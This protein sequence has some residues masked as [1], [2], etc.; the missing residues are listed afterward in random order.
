MVGSAGWMSAVDAFLRASVRRLPGNQR[1][2]ATPL[3][4]GAAKL[5]AWP[6]RRTVSAATVRAAGQQASEASFLSDPENLEGKRY[7]D[8]ISSAVDYRWLRRVDAPRHNRYERPWRPSTKVTQGLG[9]G[10]AGRAE[11]V[12]SGR[13]TGNP[14][15]RLAS[16]PG[17]K[18]PALN[19]TTWKPASGAATGSSCQAGRPQ[20]C[21]VR[22]NRAAS[23]A[24]SPYPRGARRLLRDRSRGSA[25]VV[26]RHRR[27][28]SVQ[29]VESN[30]GA[31][32]TLGNHEDAG[33]WVDHAVAAGWAWRPLGKERYASR[34]IHDLIAARRQ[35]RSPKARWPPDGW[36]YRPRRRCDGEEARAGDVFEQIG[37]AQRVVPNRSPPVFTHGAAFSSPRRAAHGEQRPRAAEQPAGSGAAA[38]AD[39]FPS[40]GPGP[41]SHR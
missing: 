4:T 14:C 17:R 36:A 24:R 6:P 10:V 7:S 40:T 26:A 31:R 13:H 25:Q 32:S 11:V 38:P 15:H 34:Y 8:P 16:S 12:Q 39:A 5:A 29:P 18:A 23:R 19:R 22:S 41:G 9:V 2:H 1:S 21:A 30:G 20:R 28:R 27:R 35:T 3:W 37:R 33:A